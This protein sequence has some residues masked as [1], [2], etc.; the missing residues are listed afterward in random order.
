[1]F[2]FLGKLPGQML[3][4]RQAGSNAFTTVTTCTMIYSAKA[5][6]QLQSIYGDYGVSGND[7][8]AKR[9]LETIIQM[10]TRIAVRDPASTERLSYF[11][12]DS[13]QAD[14]LAA[15]LRRTGYVD[16][17][18]KIIDLGFADMIVAANTPGP[19]PKAL[20]PAEAAARKLRQNEKARLRNQRSRDS[21]AASKPPRPRG[22]PAKAKTNI[23]GEI[24]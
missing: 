18:I 6:K 1:M 14:H 20:T 4:P 13:V 7:I 9:K 22:R 5:S 21:R 2:E 24:K 23:N 19:K 17:E 15:Y 16:V 3:K 10:A 12:Y 8:A 11:V